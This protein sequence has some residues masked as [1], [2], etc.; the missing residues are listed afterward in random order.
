MVADVRFGRMW[1]LFPNRYQAEVGP[2]DIALRD[3]TRFT[4]VNAAEENFENPN[5]RYQFNATLSYFKDRFLGGTH[6]FKFGA[7]ISREKMVYDRKRNGDILLE[8]NDGRAFQATLANTP[9]NS[10]HRINT[11]GLFFRTSGG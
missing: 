9:I 3:V 2:D 6:D 10:D 1:G 4:R 7:Q 11:W 5:H 8:L